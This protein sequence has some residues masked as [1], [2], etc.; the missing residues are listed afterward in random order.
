MVTVV[1]AAVAHTE[2]AAAEGTV[3]IEDMEITEDTEAMGAMGA[4]AAMAV[5]VAMEAMAVMAD[6]E[7]D[8]ELMEAV[9]ADLLLDVNNVFNPLL[10]VIFIAFIFRFWLIKL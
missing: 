2:D 3:D 5:M 6:T 1:V 8:M 10:G 7:V 9:A 4:M